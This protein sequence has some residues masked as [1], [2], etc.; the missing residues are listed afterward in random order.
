M[1]L[2]AS[3]G[4]L[5]PRCG[6]GTRGG[7]VRLR[8]SMSAAPMMSAALDD[9]YGRRMSGGRG[10]LAG[11]G[12]GVCG[13]WYGGGDGS[14]GGE[15]LGHVAASELLPTSSWAMSRMGS[16][17]L[18]E[19]WA[20]GSP[21]QHGSPRQR[22][23]GSVPPPNTPPSS[24]VH[25]HTGRKLGRSPPAEAHSVRVQLAVRGPAHETA[26]AALAAALAADL[27]PGRALSQP[28]GDGAQTR[29]T[30]GA[31]RPLD[32]AHT[33]PNLPGPPRSQDDWLQGCE[34][35]P[36]AAHPSHRLGVDGPSPSIACGPAAKAQT[37]HASMYTPH[38][39]PA[40]GSPRLLAAAKARDLASAAAAKHEA[41]ER[42]TAI[43]ASIVAA[44]SLSAS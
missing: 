41:E 25:G 17:E 37:I 29:G 21:L 35:T 28:A 40:S 44:V 24:A 14:S 2:S 34:C 16:D 8:S 32:P 7:A 27:L 33:Q 11:G 38:H 18:P 20:R 19:R 26:P 23:G 1:A 36:H 5:R 9:R 12:G 6:A 31:S 10:G 43:S 39:S 4:I 30:L 15:S 13:P 42:A 22:S 3:A